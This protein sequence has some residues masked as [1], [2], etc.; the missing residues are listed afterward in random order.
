MPKLADIK[1]C[2]GCMACVDSCTKGALVFSVADDGHIYPKLDQSLCVNCGLCEKSCPVISKATYTESPIAEAYAAWSKNDEL[3]KNSAS[4]GVFSAMAEDIIAKGG[5]VYGC[6][7]DG[8]AN[9]HHIRIDKESDIHLLQ[10]SKYTQSNTTG[11]YKQAYS[12]LKAGRTVL[13][14][15]TGCQVAALYSY[16]ESKVYNGKLI[17]VDLIC[18]G[19][20]SK[21][22]IDKFLEC[23]PMH[24]KKIISFR[25][26]E[27]GWKPTGFVYN[28]K[29]EDYEG[30]IYD[31]SDKRNLVTTGFACEMT[32]R[33]CCYQCRFAGIHRMSDYTIGDYWGVSDY[34]EEHYG[35]VSVII[36]HNLDAVVHLQ[37]MGNY[38]AID[39]TDITKVLT[40]N[41]RLAKAIDRRYLLPERK[42]LPYFFRH[43]SYNNLCKVYAFDFNNHSTWILYKIYRFIISKIINIQ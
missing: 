33:F 6:T 18:G 24:I 11:I 37:A 41:Y 25:T 29:V 42:Y 36:A 12:D 1:E 35:G 27:T 8:R 43:L 4:G 14:S 21:L 32:N 10:G 5:V 38:L 40:R 20:P 19:V 16:L 28:L 13:F 3:R 17:T 39:K 9:V 34:K 31:Y 30:N 26:K 2:T 15:G 7:M 23:E 22:L